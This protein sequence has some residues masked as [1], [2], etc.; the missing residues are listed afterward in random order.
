[1]AG[2][3]IKELLLFIGHIDLKINL[4]QRFDFMVRRISFNINEKLAMLKVM[5]DISNHYIDRLPHAY[6]I[7]QRESETLLELLYCY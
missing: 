3:I 2:E 4:K 1:M 5:I 7:I 6:Q